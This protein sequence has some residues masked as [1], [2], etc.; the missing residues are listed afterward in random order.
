[1]DSNGVV[2]GWVALLSMVTGVALARVLAGWPPQGVARPS[3]V[4]AREPDDDELTAGPV[5]GDAAN[6]FEAESHRHRHA[7]S[8]PENTGSLLDGD[9]GLGGSGSDTTDSFDV[10][11]A[12]GYP[13]PDGTFDV[14]GNPFGFDF[15]D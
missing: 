15:F 12:N 14:L 3:R 13:M 2:D 6:A 9:T 7:V 8:W 10:N 5:D 11:P 1:M 4:D